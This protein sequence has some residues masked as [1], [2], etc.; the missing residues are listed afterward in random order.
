MKIGLFFGG[1][2]NER[3]ISINSARAVFEILRPYVN[4]DLF[5]FDKQLKLYL[6]NEQYIFSNTPD[7]FDSLLK[8]SIDIN[9]IRID[10]AI[11]LIH[12]VFGEDGQIQKIFEKMRIP[13]LFSS[14]FS[15][16]NMFL[17]D[18]C[19]EIL[20]ENGF[21]KWD[22]YVYDHNP[23]YLQL[24]L[25]KHENIVLKP[26]DSGSSI[27]TY[28][29]NDLNEA[30]NILNN[31]KSRYLVEQRHRGKEFSIVVVD[32]K[33]MMPVEINYGSESF[34]N[35]RNKYFPTDEVKIHCPPNFSISSIR[36][37][38]EQAK[39]IFKTFG[40][41][42]V[43]RID[44][45]LGTNIIFSDINPVPG[46]EFNGI[47]F[48]SVIE[49]NYIVFLEMLNKALIRN[50]L[51]PFNINE[52][53]EKEIIPIL[54]GGNNS[55][56]QVSLLSAAS[57]SIKLINSNKYNTIPYL[58]NKD[59]IYEIPLQ[60]LFR[61][62]VED[63]MGL[64]ST[65]DYKNKVLT[66]FKFPQYTVKK[67]T[68]DEFMSLHKFIFLCLHGG[69]GENGVLQKKLEKN[70]VLFTGEG[71]DTSEICMNK[72]QAL[73]I[74]E[75]IEELHKIPHIKI[76]YPY[77]IPEEINELLEEGDLII[78]PCSDGCSTGVTM[79]SNL[80]QLYVYLNNYQNEAKGLTLNNQHIILPEEKNIDFILEPYIKTEKPIINNKMI[81]MNEGWIEMTIGFIDLRFENKDLLIFNPSITIVTDTIL[82][83]E[84]KFL[85]GY[86]INLTP[87]P[88][89]II[90]LE[91]VNIIKNY[92]QK[93]IEKLRLNK[94]GR[95]DFFFNNKTNE[96]IF[97]EN[98]TLPAL[99]F[100]TV[101]YHQCSQMELSPS[102]FIEKIIL[103]G[104]SRNEEIN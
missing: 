87:P 26:V 50:N 80:N 21:E 24:F 95:I 18:K 8:D 2:S 6:L 72:F 69:E 20:W 89:N 7:D 54:F 17:K 68:L 30:L 78:K 56:R 39:K 101:I 67:Y 29:T 53:K 41:R 33:P 86:G 36:K 55:E 10:F 62:T 63:I 100:T 23:M 25:E 75:K 94:Y 11:P 14:S 104:K 73:E 1:N 9:S 77:E 3:G 98:N 31:A 58:W 71:S 57:A 99:S 96:L 34:F 19:N 22:S 84:D 49:K 12:G 76:S 74:V 43:I 40:A 91:Q 16:A 65:I 79:I 51:K 61:H 13:F 59:H 46:M 66:Y 83:A 88:E 27:G 38:R 4:I 97:I 102:E 32:G 81:S 35:Y 60:F 85:A 52:N 70:K 45:F 15:C 48:Q 92:I 82:T 64:I 47:F 93:I 28:I 44:G 90:S 42:D 5:Y 37:I 103:Q